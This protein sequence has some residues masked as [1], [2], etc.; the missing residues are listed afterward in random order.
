MDELKCDTRTCHK[1]CCDVR[2]ATG[3]HLFTCSWLA[4][5]CHD[6]A[7]LLLI[8]CRCFVQSNN[9]F[10]SNPITTPLTAK[11]DLGGFFVETTCSHREDSESLTTRQPSSTRCAQIT[12]I[13]LRA[14]ASGLSHFCHHQT[15][16][17][18]N[19]LRRRL[20]SNVL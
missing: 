1:V 8:P 13:Q 15:W 7:V 19:R 10:F 14:E 17:T 9:P 3:F 12:R 5:G 20:I 6:C 16:L 2:R 4:P 18:L 11:N